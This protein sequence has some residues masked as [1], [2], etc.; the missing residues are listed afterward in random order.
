MIYIIQIINDSNFPSNPQKAILNGFIKSEKKFV[1]DALKKE[2]KTERS[3]SCAI[4]LLIIENR[5]YVANVGDSR[6][7]MSGYV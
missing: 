2:G 5:C 7:I 4:M 3:G 6:A 1:E